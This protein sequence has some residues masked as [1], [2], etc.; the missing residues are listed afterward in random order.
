MNKIF[1]SNVV[2][3]NWKRSG[4][5]GLEVWGANTPIGAFEITKKYLVEGYS[6]NLPNGYPGK[7]E[8]SCDTADDAKAKAAEEVAARLNELLDAD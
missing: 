2:N 7:T 8:I 4:L 5:D 3:M 1:P 6:L